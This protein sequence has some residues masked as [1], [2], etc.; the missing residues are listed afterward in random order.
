MKL[1]KQKA[2]LLIQGPSYDDM[3]RHIETCGKVCYKS[4]VSNNR[5]STRAFV[6]RLS[7][8]GHMSVLEHGTVYMELPTKGI[9]KYALAN[10]ALKDNP[11]TYYNDDG[12]IIHVTTNYRVIMEKVLSDFLDYTVPEGQKKRY[13]MKVLTDIGVSRE[14]NRHRHF[15]VTEQSTRYCNYSKDKFGNEITFIVP[16]YWDKLSGS[17]QEDYKKVLQKAEDEYMLM[18][19]RG[20]KPE[21]ARE[22]LPLATATEAVYTAFEDDW[23]H[24]FDLRLRETTGRVHPNMKELAE[25]MYKRFT[26]N[27]IEL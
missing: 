14:I 4:D 25:L 24:F 22:F 19:D 10:Y 12:N 27:G 5:D 20:Y 3:L 21:Q 16:A 15:S 1:L 6:T 26:E 9:N 13:T 18:L 11:Y 23:R 2:E 7:K 8:M 17:E